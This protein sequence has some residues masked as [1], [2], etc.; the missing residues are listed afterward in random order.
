MLCAICCLCVIICLSHTENQIIYHF[1]DVPSWW[2]PLYS[3]LTVWNAKLVISLYWSLTGW[4][5]S[6]NSSLTL[7]NVKLVISFLFVLDI[8]KIVLGV[9]VFPSSLMN[10]KSLTGP[11]MTSLSITRNH[12]WV[13]N[14]LFIYLFQL[15]PLNSDKCLTECFKWLLFCL[16]IL[17]RKLTTDYMRTIFSPGW[18][19]CLE[20]V[21]FSFAISFLIC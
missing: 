7:R 15:F 14:K 18:N 5:F 21:H 11:H 9:S 6:L 8:M 20:I 13:K 19:V 12:N 16:K 17:F 2:F 10:C 1:T 4:W 3:Y